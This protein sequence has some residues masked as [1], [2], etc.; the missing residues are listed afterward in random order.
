MYG[1][2]LVIITLMYL[3]G[4][5]WSRRIARRSL[6]HRA[7]LDK[8]G[9]NY[10]GGMHDWAAKGISSSAAPTEQN[11]RGFPWLIFWGLPSSPIPVSSCSL[12]ISNVSPL[13]YSARLHVHAHGP[14]SLESHI[15]E[16]APQNVQDRSLSLVC[17]LILLLI[18]GERDFSSLF[19]PLPFLKW[20]MSSSV[21]LVITNLVGRY[22]EG[23]GW[24]VEKK[25]E[26]VKGS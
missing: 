23:E 17:R 7:L 18:K 2:V 8:V 5:I 12:F 3:S 19:F 4:L 14:R 16:F 25:Y 24:R 15:S 6:A 20:A 10:S 13:A 1:S 22:R 9:G 26:V 11:N 21:L